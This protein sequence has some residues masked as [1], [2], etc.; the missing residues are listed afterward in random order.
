MTRAE[1][2]LTATGA[3]DDRLLLFG[4]PLHR[5]GRRLGLVGR[6][7]DSVPLGLALGAFLWLVLALLSWTEGVAG[8]L[9]EFSAIGVH[10]RLLIALPLLFLAETLIAPR[11]ATFIETIV[12]SG[13]VP[14]PAVPALRDELRSIRRWADSWLPESIFL[15]VALLL[16]MAGSHLHL[17]GTSASLGAESTAAATTFAG[18]W[19]GTVCLTIVRFL[20][21]RWLWRLLLW[22]RFLWRVTRLDLHLVPT[23]PD[24]Q[25]GLGYLQVVQAQFMPV[26]VAISAIQASG[27]A[28]DIARGNLQFEAVAPAVVM[29]LAVLA[30][31]FLGP[32]LIV[33]PRLR[34][35]RISGLE[36]Y[37]ELASRYVIAFEKK[38][39]A[40]GSV[41]GEPFLGTPDLQSLADLQGSMGAVDELR[42]LPIS[43][44][45]AMFQLAATLLPMAPLLLLKYPIAELSQKLIERLVGS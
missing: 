14:P 4:G 8:K 1:R 31:L 32:L 24:R 7:F 13:V 18:Q 30:A 39:L 35:A 6:D 16:A 12:R 43:L 37:M 26:V 9:F 19:Y 33:G 44:R 23:H 45:L 2:H 42:W 34:A 22:C 38:W 10:V 36:S 20:L 5:L 17:Y 3:A 40:P 25:A 21:L 27:L 41:P 15:L 29:L 28:E 11:M